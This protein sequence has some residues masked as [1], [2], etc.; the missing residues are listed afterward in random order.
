MY[1]LQPRSILKMIGVELDDT[2]EG[3]A[4]Q[5]LWC[6]VPRTATHPRPSIYNH[7]LRVYPAPSIESSAFDPA[8]IPQPVLLTPTATQPST[9]PATPS[10]SHS[11]PEIE[12]YSP[13]LPLRVGSW[14]V[15]GGQSNQSL[16]PDST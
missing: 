3:K 2:H 13:G 9:H 7:W 16:H 10:L 14:S 4:K 12:P 1:I 11:A 6:H 8:A 15:S 5:S